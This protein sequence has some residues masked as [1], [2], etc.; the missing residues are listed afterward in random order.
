[1]LTV[2]FAFRRAHGLMSLIGDR[3]G[4]WAYLG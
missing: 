4:I 2:H 3:S 1:M